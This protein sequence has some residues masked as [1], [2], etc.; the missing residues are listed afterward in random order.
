SPDT[1]P[2]NVREVQPTIFGAVPRVW[3]RFYSGIVIALK[4]ATRFERWAYQWAIA[5][6]YRIADARLE[7]RRPNLIE[8]SAFALAYR[9]VLRNIRTMIGVDRCRWL[10]TGAA[11]I[12]PD[13]I[14]WYMALGLD[15]YEVYGQT[16]NTGLATIMPPDAIKLSTVGKAVPYAEVKIS[17]E[18]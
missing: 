1:V 17:P 14:R 13:L 12:A 5:A 2:E 4:D 9:L 10:F 6:G 7:R 8:R 18:S 16:E 3:E 15:M 11:P